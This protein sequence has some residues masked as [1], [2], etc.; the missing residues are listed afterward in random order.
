[1]ES[2]TGNLLFDLILRLLPQPKVKS[3]IPVVDVHSCKM[4]VLKKIHPA[5][6]PGAFYKVQWMKVGLD[7]YQVI[8][9]TKGI[10]IPVIC[11]RSDVF[12]KFK[13]V[14]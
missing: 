1:M 14:R 8:I 7:H 9:N 4:R 10:R 5:I 3:V 6:T 12:D 2:R 13:T 11:S